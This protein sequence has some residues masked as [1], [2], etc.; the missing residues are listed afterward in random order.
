ME[1]EPRPCE[2]VIDP[3]TDDYHFVHGVTLDEVFDVLEDPK[4]AI[5][6]ADEPYSVHARTRQGSH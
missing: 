4:L 5:R 2:F 1:A 3:E 6:G